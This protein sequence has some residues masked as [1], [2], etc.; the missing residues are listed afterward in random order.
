MVSC[1]VTV[2]DPVSLLP[3]ASVA[4]Q[5]TVVVPRAKVDPETGSQE[6]V[7]VCRD[8]VGGA[9]LEGGA[10]AVGPVGFEGD[11]AGH[12]ELRCRGVHDGHVERVGPRVAGGVFCRACDGRHPEGKRGR[13]KRA[14]QVTAGLAGATASVALAGKV[15][16][17]P[18]GP[19]ASTMKSLGTVTVGGVVSEVRQLFEVQLTVTCVVPVTAVPTAFTP[20]YANAIGPDPATCCAGNV[21]TAVTFSGLR[22]LVAVA[23]PVGRKRDGVVRHDRRHAGRAGGGGYVDRRPVLEDV[24]VGVVVGLAVATGCVSVLRTARLCPY[25]PRL[26]RD[27]PVANDGVRQADRRRWRVSSASA[28]APPATANTTAADVAANPLNQFLDDN[29]IEIPLQGQS[30]GVADRRRAL[31]P[32]SR[33]RRNCR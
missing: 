24:V 5:F 23:T 25:R 26:W 31:A 20:L 29:D 3:A 32:L 33:E 6:T 8:G 10:G 4:E 28:A 30:D 14:R 1:T 9:R 27:S 2:K 11:V 21:T 13:R 15:T 19:V 16:R 7:R 18:E 17:V 22:K 12:R